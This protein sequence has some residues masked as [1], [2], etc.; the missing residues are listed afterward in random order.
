[1][2]ALL[3][4]IRERLVE[5]NARLSPAQKIFA[6]S[7]VL[8]LV[9]GVILLA[10]LGSQVDYRRLYAQPIGDR[11]TGDIV[12]V[13]EGE[14]VHHILD[15]SGNIRVARE[16][17]Y[18]V[19]A[20]IAREGLADGVKGWELLDNA[21][22]FGKPREVI[23]NLKHRGLEGALSKSVS[24][25][26]DVEA[27]QVMISAP[28]KSLFVEDQRAVTA[29]VRVQLEPGAQLSDK[30]V[31]GIAALI[32]AAVPG[33]DQA[34]V[35]IVDQTGKLWKNGTADGL[36]ATT[37]R[38]DQR[39]FEMTLE[40]KA[41]SLLDPV[42]GRTAYEVTVTAELDF[43]R[44]RE[45]TN[46]VDDA[47][48]AAVSEVSITETR[49]NGGDR[50]GGAAGATAND[51]NTAQGVVRVGDA[52]N[53]N[54]EK[55]TVNYDP[56]KSRREQTKVG[57][58]LTRLSVAVIVDGS[59]AKAEGA[60]GAEGEPVYS[61]RSP[62]QMKDIEVIVARAVGFDS[63]RGDK[64]EV[65]NV[66]FTAPNKV[67]DKELVAPGLP[68]WETAALKWGVV[69]LLGLLMVLLVFRPMARSLAR[70][71]EVAEVLEEGQLPPGEEGAALPGEERL[72]ELEAE[73]ATV[74][75]KVR[76]FARENPE[77]AAAIL[78]FWLREPT[79]GA[80]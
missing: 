2:A 58:K 46:S 21:E 5:L 52:S 44:V 15:R 31:R 49:E 37:M 56:T 75:D 38:S 54:M 63:D 29:A 14:K 45:L 7:L 11:R 9:G 32:A 20:L 62:E 65:E 28:K 25:F 19:R 22:V 70:P 8:L 34:R 30:S 24:H 36:D 61:P 76:A 67:D 66:R 16:D 50:V 26:Q 68:W 48:K 53:S 43:D 41:R 73:E 55:S 74:A 57:P 10:W 3:Q 40:D 6:L 42:L 80:S 59:Y 13:L 78:R 79:E 1:M 69:A 64:M 71:P 33:L 77:H 51:P 72:A 60:E 17:V 18:R 39:R 27:A 35:S 23:E 4:R 12:K 47:R